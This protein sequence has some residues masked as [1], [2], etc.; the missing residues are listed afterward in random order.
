[1]TPLQTL[2]KEAEEKMK[3]S[4]AAVSRQ[5]AEVRGGRANPALVEHLSVSCYGTPTPLKQL[6]AITAPEPRMLVVQ[7]WDASL[8]PEVEKA[9]LQSGIGITPMNDGKLLRL[10][11]PSL[12]T[13]RKTELTKLLH[14]MAEEGR[15][16][17]RT[18]RRDANETVKKLKTD[19]Q[20]SEDD[21]FKTQHDIQKLTDKHIGGIDALLK[22]KEHDLLAA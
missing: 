12:T 18:I 15:V 19:K 22:S 9:I 11:I 5:F 14:K 13:E 4:E 10:P 17:I 21:A 3:K 7:P 8:V 1:M 16:A 20:I 2:L 6:A